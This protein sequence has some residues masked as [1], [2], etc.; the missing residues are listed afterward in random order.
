MRFLV[1]WPALAMRE[2]DEE[3]LDIKREIIESRGLVIKTNNLT[4]ALS[5]DLKSIAK[6][7]GTYERRISWNSATAYIVFV[8][9]VFG[10]LKL[11][12]DARV[13]QV[14]AKTQEQGA[15]NERLRKELKETL[16]REEDRARAE[17]RAAQF[18]EL[19]RQGKR[20]DIVDGYASL[21][22][23]PLSKTE[24]AVFT[25]AV[26]RARSELAQQLYLAGLDKMKMQRWQEAASQFEDSLRHKEDASTTGPVRLALAETQRKLS[27]QKD[28]VA[29]LQK[30]L[31]GSPPREL[32]DDALYLMAKC[33]E[34]LQA[35][36]DAKETWRELIRK[37]ADSHFAP[38]AR[39]LLKGLELMH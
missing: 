6:R 15:D 39:I 37:H 34:D 16:K 33:Q 8:L 31:E 30:L 7:Q 13:D 17:A 32:Q 10:A 3:L 5:A 21:A 29:Q 38:E 27:K 2:I 26:E 24:S 11:A 22:K 18:Y 23:E 35:W 14:T 9:V 12:W 36:N 1:L 20:A 25:D 4:N 19:V 28:A